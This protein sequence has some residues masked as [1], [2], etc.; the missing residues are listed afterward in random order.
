[1]TKIAIVLD[2]DYI[3]P[4]FRDKGMYHIDLGGAVGLSDPLPF[5][6]DTEAINW[7]RKAVAEGIENK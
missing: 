3:Y 2:G 7:L 4:I 1:M 5:K 6:S